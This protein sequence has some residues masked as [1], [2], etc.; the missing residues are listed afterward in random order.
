MQKFVK[1][2]K[3]VVKSPQNC[4]SKYMLE[5]IKIPIEQLR[6]DIMNVWGRL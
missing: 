3:N 4:Y 5:E 6:Q 1:K 2:V